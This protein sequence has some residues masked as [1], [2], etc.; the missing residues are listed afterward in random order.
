MK[1]LVMIFS[2][3]LIS[4]FN[5]TESFSHQLGVTVNHSQ[6]TTFSKSEY[7]F[8]IQNS[9]I[10][11]MASQIPVTRTKD[12]KEI[13]LTRFEERNQTYLFEKNYKLIL[14]YI[15]QE[16]A[17][18][19][20]LYFILPGVGGV[21][22]GPVVDGLM[23][24]LHDNGNHVVSL[25]NPLSWQFVIG[26]STNITTGFLPWD[27]KDS[28]ELMKLVVTELKARGLKI[29]SYNLIG[30]SLGGALLPSLVRYDDEQG[31]FKFKKAI[32]MNPPLDIILGVD[33]LDTFYSVGKDWS[34]EY[35]DSVMGYIY[36]F[37]NK[38]LN[39]K[40]PL[41]ELV[42]EFNLTTVQK[43]FI[44]GSV[45]RDSL[46]EMIFTIAALEPSPLLKT[47]VS[48]SERSA[49]MQEARSFSYRQYLED[50]LLVKVNSLEKK[51]SFSNL[52]QLLKGYDLYNYKDLFAKDNRFYI[53]HNEDDFLLSHKDFHFIETTFKERAF[54]F[55]FG[56]H[57]GNFSFPINK[58]LLK[59]VTL[60]N[61]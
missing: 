3:F 56:G 50:V 36:G 4:I 52:E 13:R 58:A 24:Q 44:I 48:R 47:P 9:E 10:A 30:F 40:K 61:N 11:T 57:C 6:A 21:G 31:Y 15:A 43:Q 22:G 39:S 8:P 49:R 33:K 12:F 59:S 55:P 28:H 17:S 53:F 2:V 37:G 42:K 60:N 32:L 19:A 5:L 25:A 20:P 7:P 46:T 51:E 45:Y 16:E 38:V 54:L 29:S 14:N 1:S 34:L 23:Q 26:A 35:R 18:E 27:I 41:P